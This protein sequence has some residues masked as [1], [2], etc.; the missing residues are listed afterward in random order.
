MIKKLK[1]GL[2]ADYSRTK[3]V[4]NSLKKKSQS[5]LHR[6]RSKSSRNTTGWTPGNLNKNSNH[7]IIQSK[8][9]LETGKEKMISCRSP[10]RS[11]LVTKVSLKQTRILIRF[12]LRTHSFQNRNLRSSWATPLLKH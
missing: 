6:Q 2:L 5:S 12:I 1:I 11:K 8:Q 4:L 9:F 10:T 3:I 7:L